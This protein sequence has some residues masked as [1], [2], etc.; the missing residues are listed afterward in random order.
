MGMDSIQQGQEDREEVMLREGTKLM[1]AA[2]NILQ[3]RSGKPL[4]EVLREYT[5]LHE[6]VTYGAS[7]EAWGAFVEQL[8]HQSNPTD[9]IARYIREHTPQAESAESPAYGCFSYGCEG[10]VIRIHFR[11]E[12]KDSI[13]P[14]SDERREKRTQELAVMFRDIKREHPEAKKVQGYSW[15]YN[16]ESYKTLF[17]ASYSTSVVHDDYPENIRTF[18]LWGQFL[19]A[20]GH[21]NKDRERSFLEKLEQVD[22]AH[23]EQAFPLQVLAASAPIED[24]YRLYGI[25]S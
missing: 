20:D 11:N 6:R 9:W 24:F 8:S 12:D 3:R 22:I 10:R 23:V 21:V 18:G 16:L 17:P 7:E 5:A 25:D 4:A 2:A 19:T 14:L 15:L 1:L 13:S